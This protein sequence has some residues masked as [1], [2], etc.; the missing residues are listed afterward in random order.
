MLRSLS[1]LAGAALLA[2]PIAAKDYFVSAI[3]GSDTNAGT[4]AAPFQTLSKAMGQLLAGDRLFVLP[5]RYT[6]TLGETF[7]IKI[8]DGVQ[9]LGSDQRSCL[10][11]AEFDVTL[12]D[13]TK[14]AV[15]GNMV[16]M[17]S[18]VHAVSRHRHHQRPA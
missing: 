9:V 5:G 16:E 6:P 15:Q 14:N 7:P 18:N 10:I 1:L 3:R 2:S 8:P 4:A 11:D 17:G 12:P 13:L